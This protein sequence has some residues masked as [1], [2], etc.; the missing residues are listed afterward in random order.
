[1]AASTVFAIPELLEQ[2]LGHLDQRQLFALQRVNRIFRDTTQ[3]LLGFKRMMHLVHV[4]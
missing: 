4:S 3:G 2:I 1:M